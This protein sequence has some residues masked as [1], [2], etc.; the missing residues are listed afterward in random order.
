M[1]K[2]DWLQELTDTRTM[3]LGIDREENIIPFQ[4]FWEDLI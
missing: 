2:C 4:S 1:G 3:Q